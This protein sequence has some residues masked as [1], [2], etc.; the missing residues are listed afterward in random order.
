MNWETA[1]LRQCDLA[2]FWLP[3]P[4]KQNANRV[5]AQT[6]RV[7]LGENLALGKK[8]ILGIDT[9]ITGADY[10]RYKAGQYGVTTIHESLEDCLKELKEYISIATK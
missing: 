9:D 5:Y 6:T 4:Q 8:I 2:L 1:G 7:E 10:L 3:N